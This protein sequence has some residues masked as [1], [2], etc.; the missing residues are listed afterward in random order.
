[1]P[2]H[3][4]K[5]GRKKDPNGI[6]T[7]LPHAIIKNEFQTVEGL[8][9]VAQSSQNPALDQILAK[10]LWLSCACDR[11]EIAKLFLN[12]DVDADVSVG[13]G[14]TPLM[15]C[16]SKE[17]VELL[18]DY[19]ANVNATDVR[20][21]TALM[22]AKNVG[23]AEA[24]L[25][26]QAAIDEKDCEGKTALMHA[27]S[28]DGTSEIAHCLIKYGA[29][30]GVCDNLGRT[31]LITAA[32][33][34]RVSIIREAI[35]RG[36]SVGTR[37]K[38]GRNLLHH[39]CE[40]QE[41][42]KRS[43]LQET[44]AA[45]KADQEIIDLVL[46]RCNEADVNAKESL[47]KKTPLHWAVATNN[48]VLVKRLLRH[49]H[50]RVNVNAVD[51][52]HR[53]PLHLAAS[54]NRTDIATELLKYNANV[55]AKSDRGWT[56]LHVA[57]DRTGDSVD[58]V[59]LL[60]KH[61]ADVNYTTRNRKSALHAASEAGNIDVVRL[62]LDQPG[63]EAMGQDN[64]G[65]TPLLSAAKGGHKEIVNVLAHHGYT[66]LLSAPELEA[67]CGYTA[68]IIEF[69]SSGGR[70][71]TNNKNSNIRKWRPVYDL[72]SGEFP[73]TPKRRE[74][75]SNRVNEPGDFR[76]IHLPANNVAWCQ[77]ILVR[78]FME[79]SSPNLENFK[80]LQASFNH[81][82]MGREVHAR[83]MRPACQIIRARSTDED[84]IQGR[85]LDRDISQSR[86]L[87]KP[88]NSNDASR[89]SSLSAM[90]IPFPTMY[91]FMP[92]VHC[93]LAISQEQRQKAIESAQLLKSKQASSDSQT[94]S[95]PH[96]RPLLQRRTT[97]FVAFRVDADERLIKAHVQS[98]KC[99]LHIRRTLDQFFYRTI[100]TFPRRDTDQVVLRYQD[101]HEMRKDP[102][103]LM[104]DQ[105]WLWIV[106]EDLI[107]TSFP[108]QWD[109]SDDDPK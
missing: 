20:G 16:A 10:A 21:K 4:T 38:R 109:E 56:P 66:A 13:S 14:Q 85:E 57:A 87:K 50:G 94:P 41:L 101:N 36:A 71:S 45:T 17:I 37:D 44:T 90:N 67:S 89:N 82:H 6:E 2:P 99:S 106:N 49:E 75:S 24:L 43:R 46:E 29:D 61:H 27:V 93:E 69:A 23:V 98:S 31:I 68:S 102:H 19:N 77:Q 5:K 11:Y 48:L 34:S 105:L 42:A 83:Y 91:L 81:E 72:L 3:K 52:R 74:K 1:M 80:R 95:A 9:R 63:I 12:N 53:T 15:T 35:R 76:W 58:A 51:Q 108:R 65:N 96:A 59:R 32:W 8:F 104:V 92:Y 86:N 103:L 79:Q 30:L 84:V 7:A 78:W 33:K 22:C 88:Q 100:G 55:N 64:S 40:D 62:L 28:S 73:V 18:V 97:D 25:G 54:D 47:E 39:L 70:T 60:L 107:I 26:H